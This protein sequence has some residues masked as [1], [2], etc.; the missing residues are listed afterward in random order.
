MFSFCLIKLLLIKFLDFS[1]R[2]RCCSFKF[3]KLLIFFSSK[4][5]KYKEVVIFSD[6]FLETEFFK[7]SFAL[8]R[9]IL[10]S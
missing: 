5:G 2:L 7:I 10:F 4:N 8:Q 9:K 6:R 3:F 1:I